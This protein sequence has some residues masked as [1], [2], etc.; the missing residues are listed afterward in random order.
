MIDA[1]GSQLALAIALRKLGK[2]VALANAHHLY[3]IFIIFTTM[4]YHKNQAEHLIPSDVFVAI[5]CPT[6]DRLGY[7]NEH[8]KMSKIIVNIDHHLSNARFGKYNYVKTSAAAVGEQIYDILRFMRFKF[9]LDI[10]ICIYTS[11]LTDTGSFTYANTT[12]TTHRIASELIKLGANPT[13]ISQYIYE[14]NSLSKLHLLALTLQ[15]LQICSDG[16]IAWATL[17]KE[18]YEKTKT[19]FDETDGFIN[20]VRSLAGIK[21]AILFREEHDK[22]KVSFRS[23][24]RTIDVNK[25]ASKFGGGGHYQAAGCTIIGKINDVKNNILAEVARNLS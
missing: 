20:Y 11:I 25:I 3:R 4:G 19:H 9:T 6:L 1:I 5:E 21:V 13:E 23:K 24:D 15:T 17:T 22:I 2:T 16:K 18:M 7:M 8:T 14:N 12:H 10:A